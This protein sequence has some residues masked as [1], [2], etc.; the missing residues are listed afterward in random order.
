M[1]A[2]HYF[3]AGVKDF[4]QVRRHFVSLLAKAC[5]CLRQQPFHHRSDVS[6]VNKPSSSITQPSRE[7]GLNC[8]AN[9]GFGGNRRINQ[10]TTK[11]TRLNVHLRVEKE[12]NENWRRFSRNKC[13]SNG[14]PLF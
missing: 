4:L 10:S 7:Y 6:F 3:V 2:V 8:G 11:V 5:Q 9:I 1:T 14:L 13:A 12:I